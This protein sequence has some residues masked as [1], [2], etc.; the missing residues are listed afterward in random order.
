MDTLVIN[1][2]TFFMTHTAQNTIRGQLRLASGA[3]LIV[4]H[5]S[6]AGSLRFAGTVPQVIDGVQDMPESS[7]P[8]FLFRPTA[9]LVIDNPAGVRFP[10]SVF[11]RFD[12]PGGVELVQGVFHLDNFTALRVNN[13]FIG[14]SETSW[15]HGRVH[16]ALPPGAPTE[17]IPV[18]T[19][20]EYLPL[21]LAFQEAFAETTTV[22]VILQSPG[23]PP[24]TPLT[25]A[26]FA[27]AQIDTTKKVNVHYN[28]S[29]FNAFTT[30]PPPMFGI[31]MT[32]RTANLDPGADWENFVPRMRSIGTAGDPNFSW[33]NP[34]GALVAKD[35][36]RM[37]LIWLQVPPGDHPSDY[38]FVFAVGEPSTVNVS[39]DDGAV[40]EGGG[41]LRT[42]TLA[43]ATTLPIRVFLSE[44]SVNTITVNYAT[45]GGSA[46]AG[47][48][49]TDQSG[50]LTFLSGEVEKFVDVPVSGEA[51]VE[52]NET[53]AFTLSNVT[54]GGGAVIADGEA[55]GTILDDDDV[56]A[57]TVAVVYPN[58]GETIIEGANVNLLWN[59]SDNV[60]VVAV[61]LLLSKDNGATWEPIAS[62]LPNSG[63]HAWTAP[64]GLTQQA[65]LR[66]VAADHRPLTSSDDSDAVWSIW[67]VDGVEPVPPTAFALTL[68]SANPSRG[69]A[70]LRLAMPREQTVRADVYDV[71]GRR[72]STLVDGVLPAGVHELRW[73]GDGAGAGLYF[74]DIVTEGFRAR[75]RLVRLP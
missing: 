40:T 39:V 74:V 41:E 36:H 37:A 12:V 70:R 3:R 68:A 26:S 42:P 63:S 57:P 54:G 33:R 30:V 56:V 10:G 35:D 5:A 2:G 21:T 67:G 29:F 51:D 17:V 32:Y 6:S 73:N 4:G 75:T 20:S 61:D 69:A 52:A 44:P 46:Q 28:L 16:K 60:G 48:D 66:V 58:G 38:A 53:F 50:T 24:I 65:R 14:G 47:S 27:G 72:L 8:G 23:D 49:Y 7:T 55:T 43:G 13:P 64:V 25:N 31:E 11:P 15:V 18:G 62:G 19:A 34:S 45:S 22:S 1:S 71:A 9:K 59:A